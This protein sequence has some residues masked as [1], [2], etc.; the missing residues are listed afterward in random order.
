ME[1]GLR[2]RP[3]LNGP[4]Y[5]EKIDNTSYAKDDIVFST[6]QMERAVAK[7]RKAGFIPATHT[8]RYAPAEWWETEYWISRK[9][10]YEKKYGANNSR[11][12]GVF[13][14]RCENRNCGWQP[15]EMERF[16]NHTC[17]HC[18]TATI[19]LLA[20]TCQLKQK[21]RKIESINLLSIH[22]VAALQAP[23]Q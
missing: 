14:Y 21:K 16:H 6:G 22:E 9:E 8:I 12:L 1:G 10:Y 4:C 5:T 18:Q 3:E 2:V 19:D 13:C 23:L 7:L 20:P 15:S 17:P 11:E